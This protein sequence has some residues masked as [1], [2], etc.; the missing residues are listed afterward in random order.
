MSWLSALL[1]ILSGVGGLLGGQPQTTTQNGSSTS[2]TGGQTN[3]TNVG[4]QTNTSSGTTSNT[5][6]L[7]PTAQTLLNQLSST[8]SGLL[9]Q[10]PNLTGY[11]SQGENQINNNSQIQA[12]NAAET[13][14]AK[15][16]SG[17]AAATS[18]NS[19]DAGRIGQITNFQNSIPL[20]KQQMTQ[21]LLGTGQGLFSSIPTGSTGTT[22]GLSTGNTLNTSQGSTESQTAGTQTGSSTTPNTGLAGLFGNL[23]TTLAGLFGGQSN[24]NGGFPSQTGQP[25]LS[26]GAP[27]Y[28]G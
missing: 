7:N 5:P 17:P 3:T 10:D 23:S 4:N 14:A 26:N 1:P 22:S 11:Q 13:N 21:S 19:I 24:G 28:G 2:T 20:L 16:V 15:G 12:Q 27:A 25:T 9:S 8:Y 6:V 18:Q